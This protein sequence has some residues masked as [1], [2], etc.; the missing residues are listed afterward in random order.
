MLNLARPLRIFTGSGSQ[1]GECGL[2]RPIWLYRNYPEHEMAIA[3][4]SAPAIM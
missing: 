2:K 3:E 4:V 1:S